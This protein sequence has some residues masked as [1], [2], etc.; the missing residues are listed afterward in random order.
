MFREFR[1]FVLPI[2]VA[3]VAAGLVAWWAELHDHI[4]KSISVG[5]FPYD[6]IFFFLPIILLVSISLGI[7][8][9][10]FGVILLSRLKIV[11]FISV[12][13]LSILISVAGVFVFVGNNVAGT[14]SYFSPGVVGGIVFYYLAF[15]RKNHTA[16]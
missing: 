16:G 15:M 8:V 6:A 14:Y 12:V 7:S 5:S 4:V 11:N 10:F 9:C 3:S 2:I 13:S 1:F